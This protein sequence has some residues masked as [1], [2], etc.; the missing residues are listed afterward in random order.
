[1]WAGGSQS[2]NNATPPL[3]VGDRIV[4]ATKVAKVE[5]KKGMV[6]VHQ[7]KELFLR[8][9]GD[10]DINDVGKAQWAIRELRTHVFRPD[11]AQSVR[12][13]ESE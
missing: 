2:W 3:R 6:F 9:D 4:Q 5:Y 10:E 7:Q 12:A 8:Q 11:E 1:M 13:S